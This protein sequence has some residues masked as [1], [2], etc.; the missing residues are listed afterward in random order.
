MKIAK[1]LNDSMPINMMVWITLKKTDF[2]R[3]TKIDIR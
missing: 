2:K 3:T 1:Y